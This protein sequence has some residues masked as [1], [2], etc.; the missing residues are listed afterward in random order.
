MHDPSPRPRAFRPL[1]PLRGTALVPGDKSISHR[2]LILAGLATGRSRIGGLSEGRDVLATAAGMRAFGARIGREGD[3]LTVDGLGGALLQPRAAL[4]MGNSGTSAR[5]L[6]GLAATRNLTATFTGDA[7][8]SRRP[9]SR[10]IAPLRRLGADISAAPGGLL[11]LTVR[12][13]LPAAPLLHPMEVASAQVK[14]AL[15]LAG[16]NTPG[17]TRIFEPVPTRDHSERMLGAFGAELEVEEAAD[18]RIL[19]LRGEGALRAQTL[20]VPGDPSAAAFLLVAALI[21]PGSEILI[22]GVGINPTRTGLFEVLREM[23]ADL[24]LSNQRT[25]CGE[26]V[27]DIAACHSHLRG[28]D[29]PPELAPS[30]IDEYPIFFIAAAFARGTSRTSGLSELRVKESDR[31]ATM[32]RGFAALGMAVEE[33]VD[34]LAITGTGGEPLPGGTEPIDPQMDHRIAMSF[35]VA[36]LHCRAP[37]T[38]ADMSPAG[39][40]FPRFAETLEGL[41]A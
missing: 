37:L 31:L 8:L 30:M 20:S 26:P 28:V 22:Q 5:L 27:A 4:A 34:G 39:T 16:L 32:A 19:C 35:A 11:P 6:M 10:I 25:E 23:G 38:I 40:S 41:A 3:S 15:L 24:R 21:V 12:G 13:L 2:A 17:I 36:G 14:S 9:M 7:S 33:T 1:G 29:V 18:G